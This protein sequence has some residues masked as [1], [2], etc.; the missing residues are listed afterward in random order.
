MSVFRASNSKTTHRPRT[1]FPDGPTE[2]LA[3]VE[4]VPAQPRTG[5]AVAILLAMLALIVAVAALLVAWRATERSARMNTTNAHGVAY[6]GKGM[7][8]QR[9]AASQGGGVSVR[10]A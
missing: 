6:T 9:P 8:P 1:E 5:V 3:P 4:P 7:T 2:R 10:R